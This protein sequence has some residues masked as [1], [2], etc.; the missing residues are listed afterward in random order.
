VKKAVLLQE[1]EK[2]APQARPLGSPVVAGQQPQSAF[3]R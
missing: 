2:Y 3:R 1:I